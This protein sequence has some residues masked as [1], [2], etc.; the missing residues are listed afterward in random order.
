M[1][2]RV[3]AMTRKFVAQ[4][5][6]NVC[7]YCLIAEED[8]FFRHQIEHIISLKHGGSSEPENLALSCVFCNSNK[9]SDISSLVESGG[10]I[11]RFFNPRIDR[12]S[13]HFRLDGGIIVAVTDI[14]SVTV[15]ILKFNADERIMEREVLISRGLYP[16]KTAL[17]LIRED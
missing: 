5:A 9:G 11:V 16:N 12:W 10:E 17:E 6:G 15:K 13:E 7:E 1:T 14:G 3:D 8:S 2:S 4:R